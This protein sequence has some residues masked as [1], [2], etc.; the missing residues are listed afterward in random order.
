LDRSIRIQR[1]TNQIHIDVSSYSFLAH[2]FFGLNITEAS[3]GTAVSS[4][5]PRNFG[6]DEWKRGM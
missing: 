1:G 2:F 3:I 6:S 5:R 4:S